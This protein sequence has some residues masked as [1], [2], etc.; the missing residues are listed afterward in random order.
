MEAPPLVATL[1]SRR[2]LF[3]TGKGGV[4]KTTVTVSLAL[5]FARRGKRVLLATSGAHDRLSPLFGVPPIGHDLVSPEPNVWVCRIAPERAVEEYGTMVVRFRSVARALTE[6]R[7]TKAFFR[8]VPG[9]YEWAVLGKAWFHTTEELDDGSPRFDVVL[10][11]APST[12]HGVDMLRVPKVILDV[13]PPGILRR[14][15]ELAWQMFRS[16]EQSGVVVV[17]LPEDMPT[18]ETIEL[19]G[20]VRAL[21][22][23][24]LGLVVNQV[25]E[26]LLERDEREALIEHPELLEVAPHRHRTAAERALHSGARR[27]AREQL[28]ARSLARLEREL[29]VPLVTLPFLLE[30]AGNPAAVRT[31]S[32]HL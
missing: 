30:G 5:A 18:T 14:D 16:P 31:L 22:L 15:A 2:F 11:D 19:V 10:F 7:Y 3:V 29:A 28:Q 26:P 6:N 24:V 12:G 21:E 13:A 32:G 4:G 1:S 9:L 17:S 27:A 20:S 8:A 25:L 23:P